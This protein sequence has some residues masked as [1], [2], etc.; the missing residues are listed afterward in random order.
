M[1]EDHNQSLEQEIIN[2]ELHLL[3]KEVRVSREEL[4]KF[5]TD[6]FVE[7]TSRGIRYTKADAFER[8]ATEVY[9]KFYCQDFQLRTLTDSVVQL[10]YRAAIQLNNKT[11][12]TLRCSTWIFQEGQW[13]LS[14]HQGTPCDPF[15]IQP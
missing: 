8:L 6:D 10:T 4:N 2:L 1:N 5:L 3:K 7:F 9:P 14:F 15:P 11:R 13:R 12:Y